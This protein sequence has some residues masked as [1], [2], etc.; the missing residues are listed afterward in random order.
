MDT[1]NRVTISSHTFSVIFLGINPIFG[2]SFFQ[3]LLI[4]LSQRLET[5][6]HFLGFLK[7]NMVFVI[8]YHGSVDVIHGKVF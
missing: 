3:K 6:I 7:I 5:L 4:V 8:L 2:I 1:E